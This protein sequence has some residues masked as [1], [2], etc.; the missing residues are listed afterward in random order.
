MWSA[1][2]AG[3]LLSRLET[4]PHEGN[5]QINLVSCLPFLYQTHQT[6]LTPVLECFLNIHILWILNQFYIAVMEVGQQLLL[7]KLT[8]NV[9]QCF[10]D[11]DSLFYQVLRAIAFLARFGRT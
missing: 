9:E 10:I 3:P 6:V 2:M 7:I 11:L 8:Q 4:S 1:F 5:L